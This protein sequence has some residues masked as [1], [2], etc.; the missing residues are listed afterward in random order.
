MHLLIYMYTRIGKYIIYIYATGEHPSTKH[1]LT[2][3]S[4]SLEK[5][6]QEYFH[7]LLYLHFLQHISGQF[8]PKSF[9]LPFVGFN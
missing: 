2:G 5:S 6:M 9:K 3:K 8:I 1:L 4:F 7:F